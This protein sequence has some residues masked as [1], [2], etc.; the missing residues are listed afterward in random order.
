MPKANDAKIAGYITLGRLGVA[1]VQIEGTYPDPRPSPHPETLPYA[2]VA[3]GISVKSLVRVV[4]VAVRAAGSSLSE[5]WRLWRVA[6]RAGFR[7][8]LVG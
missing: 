5:G 8:V 7:M 6:V 1:R 4:P 3:E 2:S